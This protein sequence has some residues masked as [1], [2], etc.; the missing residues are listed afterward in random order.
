M[1]RMPRVDELPVPAQNQIRAARGEPTE[2]HHAEKKRMTL[3]QRLANVGLGRHADEEEV[4]PPAEMRPMVRRAPQ[5][6]PEGRPLAEM[7][8]EASEYAKRPVAQRP[9]D[10][11]GRPMAARP[12]EDDH[13]DIPAFLR[14][15]G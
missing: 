15:Q 12:A 6:Q 4:D 1:P 2:H 8:P 11:H 3:L 13:L 9:M 14:R 5:A 10:A 7:R